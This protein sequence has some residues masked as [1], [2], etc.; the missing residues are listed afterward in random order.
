MY[1]VCGIINS[2][3]NSVLGGTAK[4]ATLKNGSNKIASYSIQSAVANNNIALVQG[5]PGT[6]KTTTYMDVIENRIYRLSNDEVFLYVA[7]TN[8]LVRDMFEKVC[9]YYAFLN[10]TSFDKDLKSEVRVYGSQFDF[11][12]CEEINNQV[13]PGVKVIISTNYQRIFTRQGR[14]NFHLL[15]DEASKSPL[16]SPFQTMVNTILREKRLEGSINIVG[17]PMQ[18]I[19]LSEYYSGKGKRL[20][21]MPYFI[22]GKL[23]I[24]SDE[25]P[26]DDA[27]LGRARTEITDGTFTFLDTTYRLPGPSHKAVSTGYYQDE[28]KADHPY[29]ELKYQSIVN[30][31]ILRNVIGEG[32]KF[33]KVGKAIEEAVTTDVGMILISDNAGTAYE[34]SYKK[35]LLYD[36]RRGEYGLVTAIILAAITKRKTSVITTYVQQYMQMQM[37]MLGRYKDLIA[38]YDKM[39]QNIGL[40]D[41]IEFKTTQSMLGAE[42][43]NAVLIMGKESA[44]GLKEKTIYFQEPELFN[45][46]LT[47]HKGFFVIIGDLTRL[48]NSAATAN[49]VRRTE[50]YK[51]LYTTSEVIWNQAGYER[52]NKNFTK[53]RSGG[54]KCIMIRMND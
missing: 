48:Y 29:S 52:K 2:V 47:R 5:P 41:L 20:L 12:N 34:S 1:S 13:V 40:R 26:S 42:T 33:R 9:Y 4:Q 38:R 53:S 10:P 6:G 43:E 24:P 21:M 50:Q 25:A 17:D 51:P 8:E 3:G 18:A 49:R 28:L 32:E 7:P 36:E 27:I 23:D 35:G 14:L 37:R 15:I 11:H 44:G 16:H 54:D 19:S 45:V 31:N 39:L 22:R 46:Q 30:A